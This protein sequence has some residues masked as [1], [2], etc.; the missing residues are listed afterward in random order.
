MHGLPVWSLDAALTRYHQDY[1]AVMQNPSQKSLG[2]TD[3]WQLLP[4]ISAPKIGIK[5]YCEDL[6][7]EAIALGLIELVE[8]DGQW[9]YAYKPQDEN[10]PRQVLGKSWFDAHSTLITDFRLRWDELHQRI[11]KLE[12]ADTE[13][14]KRQ[15]MRFY[16]LGSAPVQIPDVNKETVYRLLH[17]KWRINENRMKR[18]SNRKNRCR[19][20]AKNLLNNR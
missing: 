17:R 9:I 3:D 19:S 14:V 11:E 12:K 2:C 8:K 4:E 15:I 10:K 5:E 20:K 16:L 18:M 1:Q 7:I 6:L 13:K